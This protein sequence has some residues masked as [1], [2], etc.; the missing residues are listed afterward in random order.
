[1]RQLFDPRICF[2]LFLLLGFGLL[3]T[4]QGFTLCSGDEQLF[5]CLEVETMLGDG[6]EHEPKAQHDNLSDTAE[7]TQKVE[8]TV[9]SS[10]MHNRCLIHKQDC[11]IQWILHCRNWVINSSV[12]NFL[13]DILDVIESVT[14]E[15]TKLKPTFL[16]LDWVNPEECVVHN[17]VLWINECLTL[18][19]H[20]WVGR[21]LIK[22][23]KLYLPLN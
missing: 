16:G 6:I 20:D 17:D 19:F 18:H 10:T 5:D 9:N 11:L 3:F 12:L 1:M 2:I 21:L 13:D 15:L 8:K 7:I 22:F 23:S 14:G 4:E